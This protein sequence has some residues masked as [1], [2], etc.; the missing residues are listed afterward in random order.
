MDFLVPLVVAEV[1]TNLDINKLSGLNYSAE[2]LKRSFPASRYLIVTETVDFSLR[3]NY[4]AG[5]V[6]EIYV[7]RRAMRSRHRH[8]PVGLK[9]DV[10]SA[11]FEDLTA[12]VASAGTPLGHVYTRLTTGKLING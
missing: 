10:F 2:S 11:F 6:D 12:V 7:L 5:S 3:D 4:V 8:A 1:K 9:A